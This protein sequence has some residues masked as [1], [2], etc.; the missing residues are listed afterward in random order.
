MAD[1]ISASVST[2]RNAGFLASLAESDEM[3]GVIAKATEAVADRARGFAPVEEGDY[4]DGIET[5]MVDG[6]DG[7]VGRVNATDWK[8]HWIEWGSRN[9]AVHAPLRR[10]VRAAGLEFEESGRG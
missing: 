5:D 3:K 7:P 2:S 6:P 8:S 4:R 1:G 10:G 9:N